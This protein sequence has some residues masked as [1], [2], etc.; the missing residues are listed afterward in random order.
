M[1]SILKNKTDEDFS[2]I[3]RRQKSDPKEIIN[4]PR[5]FNLYTQ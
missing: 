5:P 2:A 1:L 4:K 3:H